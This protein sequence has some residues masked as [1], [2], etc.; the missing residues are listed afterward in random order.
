MFHYQ[1]HMNVL[2]VPYPPIVGSCLRGTVIN[3]GQN[4]FPRYGSVRTSAVESSVEKVSGHL[5]YFEVTT[6]GGTR[7]VVFITDEVNVLDFHNRTL[8]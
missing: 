4:R 3:D 6:S 1:D 8:T 7:Y 5:E 2:L